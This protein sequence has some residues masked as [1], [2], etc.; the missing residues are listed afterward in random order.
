MPKRHPSFDVWFNHAESFLVRSY[1][2]L[3]LI[4]ELFWHHRP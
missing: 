4:R 3:Q 2:L 1:L